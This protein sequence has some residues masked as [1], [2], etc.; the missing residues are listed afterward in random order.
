MKKITGYV[1]NYIVLINYSKISLRLTNYGIYQ[2]FF[3]TRIH[4][5]HLFF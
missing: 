5:F 1:T 2:A 4:H 3:F